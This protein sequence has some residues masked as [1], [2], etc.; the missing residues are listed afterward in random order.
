MGIEK[1][2]KKLAKFIEKQEEVIIIT[3]C[4]A[5]GIA[6]AAIAKLVLDKLSIKNEVIIQKYLNAE[7]LPNKFLWLIDLG[8]GNIDEIKSK[9]V[10]CDH[11][12]SLRHNEYAL[13]PF[14]YGID[15]ENEISASGLVYLLAKNFE[16]NEADLAILGAIGDL[17]DLKHG[18]LVGLNR[19]ILKESNIEIKRDLRIYGR[20]KPLFKMLAYSFFIPRIF[21]RERNAIMF[22]K[23]L[24]VNYKKSWNECS[25]K[26]K[27]KILSKI[28]KVLIEY[29]FSYEYVSNLFG[30][31]Y[32]ING[33]DLRKYAAL[34]NSAAKY[35]NGEIALKMCLNKKF[36]ENKLIELH[37]KRIRK[38]MEYAKRSIEEYGGLFFFHGKDFIV[39][40]VVGTIAGMIL[41]EEDFPSPIVA[42]AENNE[43]IKVSARAPYHLI[44][45]GLNLSVAIKNAASQL[46]GKG[47][48]HRCAAGAIIPRGCEEEFLQILDLEIKNQLS[49]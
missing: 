45:K 4:D 43:G 6:G 7:Y 27:K 42:F 9:Y 16:I 13:N 5:D 34:L 44:K 8:N 17:Q 15:G 41:R 14:L 25:K 2:A 22:L 40:T 35:G 11:H 26:E 33:N 10:I 19:E 48:G 46:G 3:H 28:V 36:E 39:D 32:E 37:K 38:Y 18:K 23:N 1:K 31:V 49:L 21:K 12:F 29:G 20:D 24:G 47:G 30:E